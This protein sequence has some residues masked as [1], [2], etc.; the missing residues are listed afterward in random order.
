M[1]ANVMSALAEPKRLQIVELLRESPLTV[2][3]I[4]ERLE[5]RQPQASKHLRVLSEAGIV[6]V[7]AVA[8]R[9]IY[10]LRPDPFKELDAWL[11]SYRR[12]WEQRY[13]RLDD[14]LQELQSKDKGKQ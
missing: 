7:Q 2:G 10:K 12:M 6:E 3:E 9:R 11:E 13:D 14:Y 4:A 1:N 5:L 8:N